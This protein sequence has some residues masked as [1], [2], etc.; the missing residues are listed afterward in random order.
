MYRINPITGELDYYG[1]NDVKVAVDSNAIADYLGAA[2]DT[3]VLRTT[4]PL[5]KIDGGNYIT[6]EFDDTEYLQK[7]GS[8]ALT[9][10]WNI[11]SYP[12]YN[13]FHQQ[14]HTINSN[15]TIEI[16]S[17]NSFSLPEYLNIEGTLNIEG[18][19]DIT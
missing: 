8:V 12:I 5:T 4:P 10:D 16:Y 2:S 3:G 19:L 15:Q 6:L 17:D 1:T 11:G 18:I 14:K 9:G 7:D 13:A